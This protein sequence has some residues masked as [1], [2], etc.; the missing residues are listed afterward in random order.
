MAYEQ[1]SIEVEN[2]DV[3]EWK[4]QI[5]R[6]ALNREVEDIWELDDYKTVIEFETKDKGFLLETLER[7]SDKFL[8]YYTVDE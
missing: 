4:A 8:L 7:I 3:E 6:M 1:V 2:E 5:D